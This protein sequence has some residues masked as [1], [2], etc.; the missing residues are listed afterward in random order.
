[1]LKKQVK[2]IFLFQ[3]KGV[4]G[5]DK[6]EVEMCDFSTSQTKTGV[7]LSCGFFFLFFVFKYTFGMLLLTCTLVLPLT[8]NIHT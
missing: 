6:L 7:I 3:I 2:V 8:R 5:E 1:M 4:G